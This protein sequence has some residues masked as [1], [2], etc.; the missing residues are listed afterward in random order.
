[1]LE[2]KGCTQLTLQS[3]DHTGSETAK[4]GLAIGTLKLYKLISDTNEISN[5][6]DISKIS[7]ILV[8]IRYLR[9]LI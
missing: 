9:Y 4:S 6:P 2:S 7:D 8:F 3:V 1:M 5:I